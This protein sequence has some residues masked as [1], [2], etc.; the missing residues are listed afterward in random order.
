MTVYE[1]ITQLARRMDQIVEEPG[2]VVEI[3][4][5]RDAYIALS[6]RL[7]GRVISGAIKIP[8][9]QPLGSFLTE[10]EFVADRRLTVVTVTPA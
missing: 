9:P 4:V 10:N 7:F 1:C 5:R 8:I 2:A 3:R 6:E